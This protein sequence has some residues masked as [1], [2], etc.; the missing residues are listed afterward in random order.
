MDNTL[1]L[2][3]PAYNASDHLSRLLESA[4]RQTIP[5]DEI[6]VYDDCSTDETAKVARSYGATV[7]SGDKNQGPSVGRKRLADHTCAEWIHF[8]DADD[9]L[10]PNFVERS[11]QWMKLE[12][13]PDVVLFSFEHRRDE[14]GGLI[15][16]KSF[17]AEALRKDPVEYTIRNTIQ[18]CGIYNK[19]SFLEAGG[20]DTDSQFLY[21]EDY[22]MHCKLAR[23]GLIFDADPETTMIYYDR[24]GSISEDVAEIVRSRYHVLE[25]AAR[26]NGDTYG[27][28][29]A[30]QL[31]MNAR[32]LAAQLD[33]DL[34]DCAARLA[35]NLNGRE[36]TTGPFWFRT[37]AV[38]HPRLA[39]RVQE[40]A[41]RVLKPSLREKKRYGEV[42]I[43][44]ILSILS[45]R[46]GQ[47]SSSC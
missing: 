40:W 20:I 41:I 7:I 5:F 43:T 27:E 9:E 10:L 1:A 31:W 46:D 44:S 35:V 23:E 30:H 25:K 6:L 33:W 37:I 28:V 14:D 19:K 32:R 26:E 12:D 38:I 4:E 47:S 2:C 29:V 24:E 36:P 17:D 39:L 8:H 13:P 11:R 42:Q 3:I 45:D 34:A 22:A 18:F 21:S 15:Q 16:T